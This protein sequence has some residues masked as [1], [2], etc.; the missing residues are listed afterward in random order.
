VEI[1]RLL[2]EKSYVAETEKNKSTPTDEVRESG[3]SGKDT[4]ITAYC[5]LSFS[6]GQIVKVKR[7][8]RV[9]K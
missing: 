4:V 1:S 5:F 3:A 8:I 7:L 6:G 9:R 2:Q